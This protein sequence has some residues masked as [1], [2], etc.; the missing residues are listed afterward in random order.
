[1]DG[2]QTNRMNEF[3]DQSVSRPPVR[4]PRW[5]TVVLTL[6]VVGLYLLATRPVPPPEGWG[7]D[8]AAAV[9][10]AEGTNRKILVAFHMPGCPPC[11][12]MERT[13][14][15]QEA[16]KQ[17]LEDYVPVRVDATRHPELAGRFGAYATPTYAV[18]D[19][20]GR[21]LAKC[22]GLQTVEQFLTFLQ[23]APNS[24]PPAPHPSRTP[25]AGR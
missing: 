18:V 19:S 12:V 13:V 10:E 25:P 22:E 15:N 4:R 6:A 1:M 2:R 20:R 21:L 17:G 16:I 5:G 23:R 7:T 14:F 24:P 11:T 9:T 8:Y 3:V